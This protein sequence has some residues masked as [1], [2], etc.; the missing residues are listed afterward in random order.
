MRPVAA[1]FPGEDTT[2]PKEISPNDLLMA[3][4]GLLILS[5]DQNHSVYR[6]LKKRRGDPYPDAS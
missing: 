4:A 1:V 3:L 5:E 6:E 2:P